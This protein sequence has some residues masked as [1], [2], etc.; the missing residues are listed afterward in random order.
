MSFHHGAQRSAA[1]TASSGHTY[2]DFLVAWPDY[3]ATAGIDELRAL[4]YSRLDRL[5]HV[6]LDYTGGGQYAE[7]QLCDHLALLR[8]G[9]YGNPHSNNPT[10]LAM[11][12][13][14]ESARAAVLAFFNADPE[15]YTAIFTA[16]ASGALKLVGESYPFQPGGR[17]TCLL[18]TSPSPRD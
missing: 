6:Y 7:S 10:S 1:W 14:V 11:T 17:Y 12:E 15:E 13:L 18:Y 9:V 5:G 16:N 4:E 3:A 2:T 8:D